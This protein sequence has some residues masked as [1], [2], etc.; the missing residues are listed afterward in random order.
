MADFEASIRG[1]LLTFDFLQEVE[2]SVI[3]LA[4]RRRV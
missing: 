4:E 2:K 1:R 3:L